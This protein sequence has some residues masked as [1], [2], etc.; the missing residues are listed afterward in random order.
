MNRANRL[1]ITLLCAAAALLTLGAC[2]EQKTD[3]RPK[4]EGGGPADPA[5][6]KVTQPPNPGNIR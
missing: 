6:Y 1:S 3:V 2:A 5:P 4:P